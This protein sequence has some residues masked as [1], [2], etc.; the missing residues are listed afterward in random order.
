[1]AT[2]RRGT[3]PSQWPIAD[4]LRR[5]GRTPPPGSPQVRALAA[6]SGAVLCSVVVAVALTVEPAP[7]GRPAGPPEPA[8]ASPGPES[9]P[10][11]PRG[12]APGPAVSG[13]SA[14]AVGRP[15]AGSGR[16]RA[17]AGRAVARAR[18]GR[19]NRGGAV[20]Q[21]GP[22]QR[23]DTGR[24]EARHAAAGAERRAEACR[25]GASR[26]DHRHRGRR[27]T[28]DAWERCAMCADARRSADVGE[29]AGDR[30]E[31]RRDPRGA[32]GR[33]RHGH[34]VAARG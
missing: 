22:A 19:G 29:P 6:V 23:A 34:H 7:T 4:L 3:S 26:T 9:A 24:A 32:G 18:A 20:R 30:A 14:A 33:V 15:P 11:A 8:P 21:D 16:G 31:E 2:H 13:G 28:R 17:A 25:R 5:E 1:M 10:A 27:G 12:D